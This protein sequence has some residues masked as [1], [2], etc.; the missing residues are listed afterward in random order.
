[1]WDTATTFDAVVFFG[2]IQSALLLSG[3]IGLWLRR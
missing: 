1:M 2:V 3:V